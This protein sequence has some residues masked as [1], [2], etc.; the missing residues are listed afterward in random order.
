[1]DVLAYYKTLRKP[2]IDFLDKH[3]SIK[4]VHIL[5]TLVLSGWTFKNTTQEV[6]KIINKV[7]RKN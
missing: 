7:L 4:V 2:Y 5:T 3:T 6:L 1:M